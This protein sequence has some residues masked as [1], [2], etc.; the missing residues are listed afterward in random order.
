MTTTRTD[1]PTP[2][3][4]NKRMATLN[5]IILS[6]DE[7]WDDAPS[8]NYFTAENENPTDEFAVFPNPTSDM[9]Q[10]KTPKF[11][12]VATAKIYDWSGRLVRHF[13]LENNQRIL[14]VA[15]WQTG[16]YLLTV[17]C[18]GQVFTEKFLKR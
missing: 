5:T 17:E 2:Q 9:L 14:N 13:K 11:E 15:D 8:A 12:G 10:I 16:M 4:T 6:D 7:D 3:F 1:L 18:K